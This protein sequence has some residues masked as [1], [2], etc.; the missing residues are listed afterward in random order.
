MIFDLI[1]KDA[2][3]ADNDMSAT[4]SD[5]AEGTVAGFFR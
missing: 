2:V 1:L 5:G 4:I 3:S